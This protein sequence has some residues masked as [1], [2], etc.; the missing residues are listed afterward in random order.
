MALNRLARFVAFPFHLPD[1]NFLQFV[2]GKKNNNN[3]SFELSG[4]HI[5]ENKNNQVK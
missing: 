1:F 4:H 3:N 5:E 2:H